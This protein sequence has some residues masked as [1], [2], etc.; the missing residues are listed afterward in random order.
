MK[1]VVCSL[2]AGA[3]IASSAPAFADEA[4]YMTRPSAVQ[5]TLSVRDAAKVSVAAALAERSGQRGASRAEAAASAA[6]IPRTLPR[7]EGGARK[8]M[9]GGGG[10]KTGMIIG[11]VT[12]VAG[13][14]GGY[15]IY[16]QMK[17]SS[18]K[19]AQ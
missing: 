7:R 9:T 10:S 16:K 11:L 15:M 3:L 19:T 2:L 4:A 14:A 18:K 1:K 6:F 12:T 8:Q 17:D 13:A 5:T